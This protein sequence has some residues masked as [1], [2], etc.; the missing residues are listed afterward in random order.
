LAAFCSSSAWAKFSSIETVA[1][2]LF[3]PVYVTSA[4]NDSSKL[5]VVGLT[6]I[7]SIVDAETGAVNPTPFLTLEDTLL[8]GEG[9]ALGLAFHPDYANNGKFYTYTTVATDEEYFSGTPA[10]LKTHVR[11]FTVSSD[12]NIANPEGREIISWTRPGIVHA[13][14]WIGFNPAIEPGQPQYLHINSGDGGNYRLGQ[15]PSN[16]M[17]GILRID[18]D[19]DAYPTDP[20]RNYAIPADNPFVSGGGRPEM[21]AYGLRN[22]WR[23]SFDSATGDFWIGDVGQAMREEVNVI[24]AGTSGQNFGWARREGTIPF[25]GGQ[26]LPGDVEPVYEYAHGIEGLLGNSVI[27][28]YIYRGAD[29]EVHGKYLFADNSRNKIFLFD[30]ADPYGTIERLDETLPEIGGPLQ[31]PVSMG[32]DSDGNLYIVDINGKIFRFN[33]DALLPGDYDANGVVDDDDYEV[34][35]ATYGSTTDLA[36]DGNGSGAVRAADYTIWRDNLGA[37]VTNT[38]SPSAVPEPVAII[39]AA[40]GC[41][42]ATVRGRVR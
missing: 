29:P 39:A 17:G 12:P 20:D 35:A 6:G 25:L 41:L 26:S 24:P 31:N 27:G 4:P 8:T 5:F 34:F 30:P 18:V 3:A 33:T 7:I 36:A 32:S 38:E 2:G 13:A 40:L 42:I 19:V 1:T 10:P 22:P 15:Q 11:E 16:L 37:S 14:G 28:G 23:G 9:G 21:I